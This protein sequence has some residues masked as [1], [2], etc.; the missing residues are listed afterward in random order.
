MAKKT[1]R[2][3][4]YY[5]N[6]LK[7]DCPTIYADLVAGKYQ[8]VTEAAI[9]AGLKKPR[10]RLHELKNAWE[11]ASPSEKKAF[12]AWLRTSVGATAGR[13]A[14]TIRIAPLPASPVD[15][16]GFIKS[17]AKKRIHDIM[18]ARSIDI[19]K[20][21]NETGLSIFDTSLESALQQHSGRR[22][23]R[24]TSI[25]ALKKWLTANASV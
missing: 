9:A 11:K 14:K 19:R 1:V 13:Q 6:R 21:R 15:S 10:T 3:A 4:A 18:T 24:Q 25:T 5:E 8:T 2:D 16:D 22:L 20:I 12:L 23:K 17:W 7:R